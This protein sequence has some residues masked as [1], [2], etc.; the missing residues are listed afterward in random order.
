MRRCWV[1]AVVA[2]AF[3]F[4]ASAQ[5]IALLY[6]DSAAYANDVAAKLTGTGLFASITP[7]GVTTMTPTLQQ[8]QAYDAV[9][10][11]TNQSYQSASAMGDVLA[12]YVDAGGGVVVGVF[13]TSTTTANRS[14]TGRW[15]NGYDVIV[16][17]SGNFTGHATLGT[18]L[19][20]NHP[21]MLGVSTF[22]GGT[23]SFR[24]STTAVTAGSTRIVEWSDGKTLIAV[25]ASPHR[26]D[27]GFFP[28]SNAASTNSWL[29]TTDGARLMANAL[30]YTI[31]EPSA[32]A[33]LG[34]GLLALR[35]R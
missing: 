23:S 26:A 12:D 32:V 17:R 22:D 7:I 6:A 9:L 3:G 11:W 10:T 24:P 16:P 5:D 18:I 13:A 28:V 14:L 25:G 31:P 8:L 19:V 34:L 27:L 30:L 20:P 2:C 35:R 21:I 4:V 29:S 33:L 15:S 1:A